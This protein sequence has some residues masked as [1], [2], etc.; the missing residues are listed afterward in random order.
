MPHLVQDVGAS[1]PAFS[2][3]TDSSGELNVRKWGGMRLYAI[4]PAVIELIK[5]EQRVSYHAL[6]H[7]FGFD[8]AF[9]DLVREELVFKKLAA[10]QDGQGLAWIGEGALSAASVTTS[11][12][13]QAGSFSAIDGTSSLAELPA[14][15]S[16]AAAP[17]Q[18]GAVRLE[19]PSADAERRQL[20]VMF[21]DL[22][23]S[24][25]LSA[26]LDPEDLREVVRAYQQT[27][28]EV[29]ARFEGHIAQYLGDGLLVYFGYPRAHEDDAR[30]AVHA[31]LEIV[32]AMRALNE[33][34]EAE[35]SIRLAV[36]LG[37]HTGV[38]V[39][40][41]VGGG[42]RH[43]QLAL[44]ETPNIAARIQGLASPDAVIIS[45]AT[46]RL[47]RATF[48]LEDLGGQQL[49][50]VDHPVAVARVS[51]LLD[52]ASSDAAKSVPGAP[53]LIGRD[54]EVGLLRR[55]W[56]QS[57]EGLGQVVVISGEP[58]IGKTAL[59]E[60][61][62]AQAGREGAT[63]ITFRCSPYHQSSAFHPPIEHLQRL[64]YL[65]PEEPPEA[66][67]RKL[68]R[69]LDGYRFTHKE[70]VPL[71]AALLSIPVPEGRYPE[72]SSIP[73]QRK[74][75]TLDALTGWLVEEAE[76]NPLLVVWE[77]IHWI[78]PS[79]LE[80]LGLLCDQA[81]TVGMLIVLT[82][83][84]GFALPWPAR[85]HVTP[86]TLNRLERPQV[87]AMVRHLAD[88]KPLSGGVI[89]HVVSKTDGV[90]L[91]VEELTKT[92]LECGLLRQAD[93]GYELA[94]SLSAVAI[95]STLQDLL[96]ARL[97]RLPEAREV[98]QLGAVLGREFS[99]D[100]ILALTSTSPAELESRL[101][102]LV[103]AELLYHRG[104][105]P[106]AKYFFKHALIRDAAYASLLKSKRQHVH[107]RIA[108]L[109]EEQFPE[110]VERQPELVARHYS[111]AGSTEK[112]IAYWHRAGERATQRSAN[113][114][115][116]SHFE[117]ALGL[118]ETLPQTPERIR[119]E[120]ALQIA[121]GPPLTAIKS[122][123]SPEAER[124]YR[125]AWELCGQMGDSAHSFP[126]LRGV[127]QFY[128]SRAQHEAAHELGGQLLALAKRR[129]DP[130]LVLEAERA[131]AFTSYFQGDLTS[132]LAHAEN[133]L[134]LYD[135]ERHQSLAFQY[136]FD[137]RIVCLSCRASASWLLGYPDQAQRRLDEALRLAEGLS[138]PFSLVFAL[139]F[140]AIV[141]QHFREPEA[142]G[143]HA[144]AALLLANEHGFRYWSA[145]ATVL[146]G[147]ALSARR[148]DEEGIA[149]IREGL[150]AFRATGTAMMQPYLLD[151]L[152]DACVH[153]ARPQ[154]GQRASAEALEMV[155]QNGERLF[156]SELRR[157]EGE[158][159]LGIANGAAEPE[160]EQRAENCFLRAIDIA[161]RQGGRSLELRSTMSLS[162]LRQRQGREAE[163]RPLLAGIYG[164]FSEGFDS[165][166]LQDARS[167]LEALS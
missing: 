152:A 120:L 54:E 92:I 104:R 135:P 44:G 31:G 127:W 141:N 65:R 58:G 68:E 79:S 39:V 24:T 1:G 72:P 154:E 105:P 109:I 43:E 121:L 28:A 86:I 133:S 26:E 143:K 37:I 84:T 94:G 131:L 140:A 163:A 164:Q 40:G 16:A 90:P 161:H 15:L 167:L 10:D 5:R 134:A 165:A 47:V 125:R 19:R 82:F 7:E 116:V 80:L 107:Q 132:A 48:A 137:P 33:R 45:A 38:V 123:A 63:R 73:E 35:R 142:V 21:C 150:A 17:A 138:H 71:F 42:D 91:F 67:L 160:V 117:R 46:A 102:Q 53:V 96:M 101:A 52:E 103:E 124:A 64:L 56:E 9:L 97:D 126:A 36:R 95:P 159:L 146:Q 156:E 129:Q 166:D 49:K 66:K 61:I 60:T 3:A 145:F 130:A 8:A 128:L 148:E 75:R 158:A 115:A 136:G 59:V 87:E 108:Q 110:V 139:V 30:R 69:L 114:E 83:R 98:A 55:R 2:R 70:T 18:A 122:W 111:D 23:D 118:V 14:P 50:G 112:A 89:Q 34:L 32:E 147:W 22:V 57:K 85:S 12:T 74:Q 99:Y 27:A 151:L 88:G 25:M 157:L 20:T 153:T 6:Q 11:E 13:T 78:D 29:I 106:R 4:L 81:P 51:G 77:D 76:R 62:R 100:M 119:Q 113:A 41:D 144:E 155:R 149:R 93:G 162:R